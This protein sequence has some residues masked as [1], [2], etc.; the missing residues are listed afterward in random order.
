MLCL[1]QVQL[2]RAFVN[3]ELVFTKNNLRDTDEAAFEF[4]VGDLVFASRRKFAPLNEEGGVAK[5]TERR[6]VKGN[7]VYDLK[8]LA[9]THVEIGIAAEG[10]L[11]KYDVDMPTLDYSSKTTNG[12]CCFGFPCGDAVLKSYV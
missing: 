5:V 12:K 6:I 2:L 10:A 3:G 9:G 8:Y 4:A 11:V 1:A 7:A